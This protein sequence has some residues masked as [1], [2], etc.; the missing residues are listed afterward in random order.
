MRNLQE[1]KWLFFDKATCSFQQP[2]YGENLLDSSNEISI[3]KIC[4]ISGLNYAIHLV[5]MEH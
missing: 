3:S 4:L 1:S 2:A 5:F